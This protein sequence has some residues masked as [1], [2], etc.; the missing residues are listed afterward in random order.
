[1][2]RPGCAL[3]T[4]TLTQFLLAGCGT[5]Y[6]LDKTSVTVPALRMTGAIVASRGTRL[7]FEY[8]PDAARQVGVHPPGHKG[9]FVLQT[10]DRKQ[11]YKLKGV[12]GIA[13]LPERTTVEAGAT[14][15]FSLTF[16]AIPDDLWE[17]HVGEGEYDAAAGESSWQFLKVSLR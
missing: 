2:R 10:L 1:M 5:R 12:D 15:K 14:L 7:D 17:F 9:A 16:E 13:L 3:L 8:A 6:A 4:L 11:T